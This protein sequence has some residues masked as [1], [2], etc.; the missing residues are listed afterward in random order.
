MTVVV[1]HKPSNYVINVW[2][3]CL[4]CM[5]SGEL[6]DQL[7]TSPFLFVFGANF[8]DGALVLVA[9]YSMMAWIKAMVNWASSKSE[10]YLVDC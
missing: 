4:F 5:L 2:C 10:P 3:I 7:V 1:I 9:L 8:L 6:T